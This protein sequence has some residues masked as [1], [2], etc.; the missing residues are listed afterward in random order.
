MISASS[1]SDGNTDSSCSSKSD[2]NS[3]TRVPVTAVKRNTIIACNLESF[4]TWGLWMN[5]S[6]MGLSLFHTF[7][8]DDE[9]GTLL[10]WN[11][12]STLGKLPMAKAIYPGYSSYSVGLEAAGYRAAYRLGCLTSLYRVFHIRG[13]RMT[14]CKLEFMHWSLVFYSRGFGLFD[15]HFIRVSSFLQTIRT[16]Q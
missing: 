5:S 4:V 11:A 9:L 16:K 10:E 1:S 13:I 2:N 6:Y 7:S 12:S 14:R 8:R 15:Q 3:V